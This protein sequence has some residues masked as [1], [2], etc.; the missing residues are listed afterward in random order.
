MVIGAA[1]LRIGK[2]LPGEPLRGEM[3]NRIGCTASLAIERR[4]TAD[5]TQ[6]AD[7]LLLRPAELDVFPLQLILRGAHFAAADHR[8]SAA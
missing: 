7:P 2:V 1:D 6:L 3:K 5:S 8:F 4:I